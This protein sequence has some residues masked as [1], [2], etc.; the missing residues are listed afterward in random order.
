MNLSY[1]DAQVNMNLS[2]TR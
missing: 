1:S 2:E